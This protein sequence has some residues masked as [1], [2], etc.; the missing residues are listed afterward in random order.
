VAKLMRPY[1][2]FVLPVIV[3]AILIVGLI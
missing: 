3:G 1:C 2:T